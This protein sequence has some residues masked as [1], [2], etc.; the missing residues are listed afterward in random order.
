MTLLQIADNAISGP[1][2]RGLA[3]A[4]SLGTCL[5]IAST[6]SISKGYNLK[7]PTWFVCVVRDIGSRSQC[8]DRNNPI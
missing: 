6:M 7:L 5:L 8:T 2:S 4:D 3:N 1:I